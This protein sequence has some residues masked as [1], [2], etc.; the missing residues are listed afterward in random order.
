MTAISML[1]TGKRFVIAADGKCRSDDPLASKEGETDQAQKIFSFE[2]DN[3]K[4]AWAIAGMSSTEDGRFNLIAEA[5]ERMSASAMSAF[6]SGNLYVKRLCANIKRAIIKARREGR[7][8]KFSKPKR[9]EPPQDSPF[10]RFFF[11]GFMNGTPFWVEARFYHD[12]QTDGIEV[13]LNNEDFTQPL[14]AVG[15]DVIANMMYAPGATVDPR[16]ASYKR[17]ASDGDLEY[18]TSYIKACCD[19][20]AIEVDPYCENIGG[21]IRAAEVTPS[22]FKWL[23]IEATPNRSVE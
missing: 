1:Y 15:S 14:M 8:T 6:S 10:V 7:I 5:Q 13:W 19:P 16:L 21:R 23:P 2:T 11:L 20:I 3:I 12:E 9:S 22:G 18:V 4:M 17:E